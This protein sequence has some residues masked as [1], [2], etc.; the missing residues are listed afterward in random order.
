MIM[1]KPANDDR[2][3]RRSSDLGEALRYQ[4]DACRE[5]AALQA[6]LVSDDMGLCVAASGAGSGEDE[7]AAHLPQTARQGLRAL[8]SLFAPGLEREVEVKR[9]AVGRSVLIACAVGGGAKTRAEV[10]ARTEA[11]FRRILATT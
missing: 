9:F 1:K 8:P 11:G 5:D 3:R 2:R 6:V 7:L 10:L 4:L